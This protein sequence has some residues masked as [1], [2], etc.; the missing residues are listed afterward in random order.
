[1]KLAGIALSPHNGMETK[2]P[3]WTDS[4]DRYI[5]I[6]TNSYIYAV[7]QCQ[8][9]NVHSSQEACDTCVSTFMRK[10]CFLGLIN[11]C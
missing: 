2:V 9:D 3:Y 1:M 7:T 8:V 4:Y 11:D 10:E 5:P 6:M